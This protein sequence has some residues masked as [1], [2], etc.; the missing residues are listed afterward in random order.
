MQTRLMQYTNPPRQ[1]AASGRATLVWPLKRLLSQFIVLFLRRALS[2]LW[3][4][5]RP[6]NLRP[7]F[8]KADLGESAI[9]LDEFLNVPV[10][11]P[12]FEFTASCLSD[13]DRCASDYADEDGS[14][15]DLGLGETVEEVVADLERRFHQFVRTLGQKCGPEAAEWGL[16]SSAVVSATSATACETRPCI[17]PR[18]TPNSCWI[19]AGNY[20]PSPDRRGG[21][22]NSF[23]A[24]SPSCLPN[25]G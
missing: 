12:K 13:Y 5:R 9:T 10:N 11:V 21:T 4:S 15:C 3:N 22:G 23:P 2:R 6:E 7:L 24:A 17:G 18:K 8:E 19:T 14:W 20:V 25:R 1:T 16:R